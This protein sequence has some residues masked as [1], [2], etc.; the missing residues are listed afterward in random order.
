MLSLCGDGYGIIINTVKKCAG[1]IF[2]W[3]VCVCVCV[4]V[5][6]CVCVCV[7]A[8]ACV[9]ACVRACVCVCSFFSKYSRKPWHHT[10][11][12]CI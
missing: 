2:F 9:H 11:T 4:C 1:I 8:R 10:L 6:V 12:C 7:C 3:C 5:Y